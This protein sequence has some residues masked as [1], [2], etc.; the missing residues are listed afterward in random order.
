MMQPSIDRYAERQS[1]RRLRR[2]K[3]AV[4][5]A[6]IASRLPK[7]GN[8]GA[9]LWDIYVTLLALSVGDLES[10]LA[11]KETMLGAF[12]VTAKEFGLEPFLEG[13]PAE[14]LLKLYVREIEKTHRR[15]RSHGVVSP[16]VKIELIWLR[17]LRKLESSG[18]EPKADEDGTGL[19]LALKIAYLFDDMYQTKVLYPSAFQTL[20]AVKELGL[21][22][23]I[24]SNA[25]FYTPIALRMLL[26]REEKRVDD[27]LRQLFD[28]HLILFSYRLGVSKPNPLAFELARSRLKAMGVKPS[29]VLYVGNDVLNDMIPARRVGF[30]CVLFAGD[31]QSLT[32]REDRA[33]CAGFRPD[34]VIK[35]LPQ[36]LRIIG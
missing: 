1:R 32:L 35:S 4:V 28:R 15:K 11:Q 10:S 21:R 33:E 24:I 36:L 30:R 9:V 2:K 12:K 26:R 18:Y 19:E 34:A 27:P 14:T 5:P 25:Q 7:I 8:A 23:G 20:E 22:Q 31:A 3:Y 16:E 17:I 29:R 6:R 13:D